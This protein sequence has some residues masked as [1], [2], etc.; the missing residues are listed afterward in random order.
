[1]TNEERAAVLQRLADLDEYEA[2]SEY[3]RFVRLQ[4]SEMM[5][6]LLSEAEVAVIVKRYRGRLRYEKRQRR[7]LA[8]GSR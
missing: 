2:A 3:G 1:M 8:S 6:A 4:L 5:R 7:Y